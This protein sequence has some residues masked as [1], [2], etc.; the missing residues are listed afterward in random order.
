MAVVRQAVPFACLVNLA[1]A[2]SEQPT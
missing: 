2:S 1:S